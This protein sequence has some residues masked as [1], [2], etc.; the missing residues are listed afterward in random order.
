MNA[1]DAFVVDH[2]AGL[3]EEE[4]GGHVIHED[5]RA[6][7]AQFIALIEIGRASCRERV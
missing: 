7:P 1:V 3:I 2:V 4:D 5:L 6:F